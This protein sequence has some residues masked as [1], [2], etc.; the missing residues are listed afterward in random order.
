[1]SEKMRADSFI[2][3]CPECM[4]SGAFTVSLSVACLHLGCTQCYTAFD[5][6]IVDMNRDFY[7]TADD[8]GLLLVDAVIN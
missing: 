1:M 8:A 2:L 5:L 7:T 4:T 6:S 3:V